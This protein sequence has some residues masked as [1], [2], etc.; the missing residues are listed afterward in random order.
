M[1]TGFLKKFQ[2]FSKIDISA[3]V[4][5][6]NASEYAFCRKHMDA[7]IFYIFRI[8]FYLENITQEFKQDSTF[9]GLGNRAIIAWKCDG[10]TYKIYGTV[11]RKEGERQ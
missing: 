11:K 10:F 3:H 9:S 1:S 6:Q 8:S 2:K 4:Q 5:E 7:A